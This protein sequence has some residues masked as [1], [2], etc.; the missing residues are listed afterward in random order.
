[1][2]I[3]PN[4]VNILGV[5]VQAWRVSELHQEIENKIK[6]NQHSLVLNVNAFA[7]NLA[8]EN[9]WM[10]DLFNKADIVFCDGSGVMLGAKILGYHIPVRIT[11][12]DWI[13]QLARFAEPLGFSFFFLGGRPGIAEIAAAQLMDRFPDLRILGIHHGYFDKTPG[14]DQN[15][16]IVEKINAIKPNI[17]IIAFGMPLQE[18]WLFDNWDCIDANIALTGGA[19][20]D[21]VS[22]E[23]IRAPHWMTEHGMEWLGR[24]LIEPARLWR[25][26]LLGNPQFLWRVIRQKYGLLPIQESELGL[27]SKIDATGGE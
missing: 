4:S 9:L 20:F 18:R 16:A 19:A 7:L 26:Y 11:Y 1:M 25:R 14:S 27:S 8:Y 21:Y 3:V 5:N 22:G 13:W 2:Q 23:L 10:R 6:S 24:L 17:L 15:E 12:A